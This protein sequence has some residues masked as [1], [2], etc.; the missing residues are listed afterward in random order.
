MSMTC[1]V[2]LDIFYTMGVNKATI[3]FRQVRIN[4]LTRGLSFINS[5]IGGL[6]Q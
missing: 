3:N 4:N 2:N 6:K 5:A 1:F